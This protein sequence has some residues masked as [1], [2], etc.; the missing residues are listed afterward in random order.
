[1]SDEKPPAESSETD[2]ASSGLEAVEV[3]SRVPAT[4]AVPNERPEPDAIRQAEPEP[5]APPRPVFCVVCGAEMNRGD[6]FCH[7]CG[8]D[9]RIS[10]PPAAP[11]LVDSNP[12]EFNRLAALLLCLI[13]GF[14]GIHRFYV[15]KVGTGLLWLLTLGFLGVGQIF[16]LIL[17]ATGE[18]RDSNERRVLRWSDAKPG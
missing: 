6:M 1:M 10:P 17:I 5:P 13:L 11:R 8:W 15:G 9:G 14:L 4:E 7:A 3:Q 16:D 18:F 2:Q 12:S